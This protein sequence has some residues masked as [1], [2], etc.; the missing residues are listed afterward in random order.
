MFPALSAA[1]ALGWLNR[2]LLPK[3]LA[4]PT[5]APPASVRIARGCPRA[6]AAPTSA[7]ASAATMLNEGCFIRPSEVFG[8]LCLGF[9]WDLGFGIWNFIIQSRSEEHTSE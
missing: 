7:I 2:A 3:P 8:F 9:F 1:I 4:A 6:P 5:V